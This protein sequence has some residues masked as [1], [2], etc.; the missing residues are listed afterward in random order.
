MF[1]WLSFHKTNL[2]EASW[3]EEESELLKNLVAKYV[4]VNKAIRWKDVCK[5]LYLLNENSAKNYRTPKQCK[6]HWI[7]K[8]NPN[9]KR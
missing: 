7:C 6:E 9:L 3:G 2:N 8:L 4:D 1:K 5:K